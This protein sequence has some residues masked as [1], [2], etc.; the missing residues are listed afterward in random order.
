MIRTSA[1]TCVL[2]CLILTSVCIPARAQFTILDINFENYAGTTGTVPADIFISWNSTSPTSF[3]N[4]T[5]N[6]GLAAPSY[7]FGNDSNYIVTKIMTNIDSISFWMKGNG[8]PLSPANELRFYYSIDSLNYTLFHTIDSLPSTGTNYIFYPDPNQIAG[9]I[10]IEYGK[11]PAGG[12]LAFDDLKIYSSIV[13]GVPQLSEGSNDVIVYPTPSTGI[14]NIKTKP[15]AGIPD[16]EVYDML[17]NK[18]DYGL[19]ERKNSSEYYI[20]LSYKKRGFYFIKIRSGFEFVTRRIT[21]T[22]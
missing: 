14:L 22:D 18:V 20:D 21:L 2:I 9:N 13:I 10:K 7:K 16:V 4:S 12:N 5:G 8:T 15:G 17:G 3:Y 19:V 6:F 11:V 1:I